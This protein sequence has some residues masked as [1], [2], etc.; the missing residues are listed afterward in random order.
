MHRDIKPQNLLIDPTC[1]VLKVCDFGSA[2]KYDETEVNKSVSYICSR[3]YRA[4]ELMFGAR[5]YNTSIDIWS[6]ACVI[7]ELILGEPLFKGELPHSQLIE[8]INKLGSPTDE[9]ILVMNPNY[10]RKGFPRIEPKA[11]D[12]V[13]EIN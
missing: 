4:P 2:K 13:S 10:K 1:H 5:S 11:W 8:I 7:A 6:A 9:Q 12:E 3:Y